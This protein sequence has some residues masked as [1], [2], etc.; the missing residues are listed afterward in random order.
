M[1]NKPMKVLN[2]YIYIFTLFRNYALNESKVTAIHIYICVYVYIYFF[3][4]L[5]CYNKFY[6]KS[7][8]FLNFLFVKKYEAEL[9]LII[10]NVS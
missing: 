2:V 10:R 4:F 5:H 3:L 7:M 8:L 6:F 9:F 1:E